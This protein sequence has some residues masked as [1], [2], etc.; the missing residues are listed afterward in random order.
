VRSRRRDRSTN[1]DVGGSPLPHPHRDRAAPASVEIL[2]GETKRGLRV[3]APGLEGAAALGPICTGPFCAQSWVDGHEMRTRTRTRTHALRGCLQAHAA[4]RQ[5]QAAEV[6][7]VTFTRQMDG[8][9]PGPGADVGG[10]SPVPVQM[11]AGGVRSRCK[12]GR[13]EPGPGAD[14]G[15]VSPGRPSAGAAWRGMP[16]GRPPPYAARC[17]SVRQP[18]CS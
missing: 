5:L 11:W 15:G 8:V 18:C 1:G 7:L 6:A 13:G 17:S 16:C 12:C 14:V 2:T 4:A 10:V 9:S 3:R